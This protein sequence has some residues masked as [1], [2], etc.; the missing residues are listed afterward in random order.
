V[1]RDAPAADTPL[2]ARVAADT[3]RCQAF[4]AGMTIAEAAQAALDCRLRGRAEEGE[5]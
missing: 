5:S 1:D 2:P 3:S 4:R